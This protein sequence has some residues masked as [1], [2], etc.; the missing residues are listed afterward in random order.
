MSRTSDT[1]VLL[2]TFTTGPLSLARARRH[3]QAEVARQLN[4]SKTK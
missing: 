3:L 1:A 4:E 2:T